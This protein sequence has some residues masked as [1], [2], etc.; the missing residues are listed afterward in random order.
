MR[1]GHSLINTILSLIILAL[2]IYFGFFAGSAEKADNYSREKALAGE[3]ADQNLYLAAINEY[4]TILN[5]RQLEDNTRANINYLIAKIYFEDLFAYEKAAAHYIKAR[6]LNP[7]GSFYAEAGRNLIT[8]LE[9][10]GRM[11]DAK[12]ELDRNANI[13]STYAAH[14]GETVVAKIGDRPVY[15][16]DVEM[17]I[18]SLPPEMQAQFASRE[19]KLQALQTYIGEELIYK[20]ARREG[21]DRDPEIERLAGLLTRQAVVEKYLQQKVLDDMKIDEG[22]MRNYYAANK[23]DRYNDQ[24]FERVADQVNRDYQQE[25]IQQAVNEYVT[26]LSAVEQVQVFEEKVK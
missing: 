22:D 19:M 17:K 11:I 7:D 25:K 13:D 1:N 21:L 26:R 4:G 2:V 16:S 9:K 3:L 23:T 18:Q 10:M 24:P 14:E 6:S 8:C 15:M 12:R 20:A 5:D